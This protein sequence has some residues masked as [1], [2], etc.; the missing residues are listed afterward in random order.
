MQI[1]CLGLLV[2]SLTWAAPTFQP[3]TE[4][5]KQDC[6]EEQ[7]ITYKGHHEKRGYYIFTHVYSS[8]GR[9]NQTDI[10]PEERNKHNTALQHPGRRRKEELSPKEN[11]VQEREKVLASLEA[12]GNN[13]NS[14]SKNLPANQQTRHEDHSASNKENPNSNLNTSIY[15]ESAGN[16]G[17][18]NGNDAISKQQDQKEH[19]AARLGSSRRHRRGPVTVNSLLRKED[20]KKIPRNVLNKILRGAHYAEAFP[21]YKKNHQVAQAQ[22]TPGKS[23]STHHI[24]H[25]ADYQK[26][27]PRAQTFPSDFEGSGYTDLEERGDNGIFP[28]SGDGQPF[29]DIPGKGKAT[30]PDV[31]GTDNQTGFL[32]PSEAETRGPGYNEIPEEEDDGGS[33]AGRRDVTGKGAEAAGVSL[34]EGSNDIIGS[35]SFKELPRK[36]A[37]GVDSGSQ[38]AHQGKVEFHYPHTPSKEK[39]KESSRDVTKSTTYNEIPKNGKGSPQKL[40]EGSNKNQ[41]SLK[42]RQ[43]FSGQEKS[44]GLP[45]SSPGL[46]NEMKNKIVSH[47]GPTHEG[48]TVTYNNGRT[49]HYVPHRQN[50]ATR[51]K[52]MSQRKGSWYYRRPHSYRYPRPPR[53]HDSESS[54]SDSSSD[55]DGD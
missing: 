1:V 35:T 36:E 17:A 52:G 41:E 9:K 34:V 13:Q 27:F 16:N 46:D 53:K 42:E 6:V 39:R 50:N 21:K 2:F 43:R 29:E 45:I 11:L 51:N 10:K 18:E 26:Q 44:Q 48:N 4:K 37:N 22:N 12:N 31:E 19:G 49:N 38:N 23:K 28:F 20:A 33:D 5:T 15:L 24:Q 3:Q 25:K 54:D 7:K 8:P 40:T 47:K 30:S 14:K 55:S 32:G